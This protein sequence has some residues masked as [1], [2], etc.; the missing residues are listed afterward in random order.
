MKIINEYGLKLQKDFCI[1]S[2]MYEDIENGKFSGTIFYEDYIETI[3]EAV[4][5]LLETYDTNA[6]DTIEEW[7]ND[8]LGDESWGYKLTDLKEEL[9]KVIIEAE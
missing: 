1:K 5:W 8:E 6:L 4:A 3:E 2:N 9:K 7:I